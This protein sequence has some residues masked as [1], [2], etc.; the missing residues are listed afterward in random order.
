MH[1]IIANTIWAP[2]FVYRYNTLS[3]LCTFVIGFVAECSVFQLYT[4]PLLSFAATVKRLSIANFVSYLAGNI[5][6]IFLVLVPVDI[7]KDNLVETGGTFFIAYLI[8]VP[9]EYYVMLPLLTNHRHLVFRA[10]AMSNFVSIL[11]VGYILWFVSWRYIVYLWTG[12][13]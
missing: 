5:I 13:R 11:F 3:A 12:Y 2:I 6:L 10:V 1:L 4:R 9:I 7:H 8:T